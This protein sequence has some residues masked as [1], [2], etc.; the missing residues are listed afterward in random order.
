MAGSGLKAAARVAFADLMLGFCAA[1]LALIGAGFLLLT[2]FWAL[3]R[4]IGPVQAAGLTAAG[5]FLLAAI[6]LLI[7]RSR[8]MR[9]RPIAQSIRQPV[10]AESPAPAVADPAIMAVFVLSFVLSRHFLQRR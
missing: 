2:G 3:S 6:V 7:R 9:P 8:R 1:G 10:L 5:L 4:E